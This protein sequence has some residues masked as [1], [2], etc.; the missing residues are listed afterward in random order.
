MAVLR[1]VAARRGA[2]GGRPQHGVQGQHG[3]H[4]PHAQ[5]GPHGPHGPHGQHPQQQTTRGPHHQPVLEHDENLSDK[6][7]FPGASGPH[8]PHQVRQICSYLNIKAMR[9]YFNHEL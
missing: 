5:H 1:G 6:E 3:P 9:F 8:H 4:G 7:I 2:A